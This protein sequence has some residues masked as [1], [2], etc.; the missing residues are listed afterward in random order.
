MIPLK[1]AKALKRLVESGEVLGG[2]GYP[3]VH[4]VTDEGDTLVYVESANKVS[5]IQITYDDADLESDW[6]DIIIPHGELCAI[7][8]GKGNHTPDYHEFDDGQDWPDIEGALS[9]FDLGEG[10]GVQFWPKSGLRL[11]FLYAAAAAFRDVLGS[12]ADIRISQGEYRGPVTLKADL[13]D[14]NDVEM[15]I[16][17]MPVLLWDGED[18]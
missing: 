5:A 7:V 6:F 10:E 13:R 4:L 2:G 11:Q 18:E 1:I 17:L 15:V 8:K 16:F 3:G 9:Q 12:N 14:D